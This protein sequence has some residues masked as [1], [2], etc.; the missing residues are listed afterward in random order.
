MLEGGYASLRY[1]RCGLVILVVIRPCGANDDDKGSSYF[2]VPLFKGHKNIGK[3]IL[4][5]SE[6]TFGQQGMG[7]KLMAI[8]FRSALQQQPR[9]ASL[10]LSSL[11][12][13]LS[14]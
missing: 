8:S 1:D 14:K 13:C 4:G 2:F 9:Y 7:Y 10:Q 6:V 5:E 3:I 12:F 11:P